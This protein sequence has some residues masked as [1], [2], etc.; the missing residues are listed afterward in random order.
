M[1]APRRRL[2]PTILEVADLA[3]VSKSSVSNYFHHPGKLSEATRRRIADAMDAVGFSL[4]DAART[5]RTGRS[6]VVGYVA[7]ELAA[8]R[9]PVIANA[10]AA[11]LAEHDIDLLIATNQGDGSRERRYLSLFERQR[12]SGLIVSPLGDLEDDLRRLRDMGIP[13]VLMTRHPRALDQPAVSID[14][15]K[16]GRLALEHLLELG[17][18]RVGFITDTLA[19]EQITL[20]FEGARAVA[21]A[22]GASIEVVAT[23]ERSVM[24]GIATGRAI[25]DLPAHERPD[26]LFCVNDLVAIGVVHGLAGTVRVPQDVAVVGYDDIEFAQTPAVPLTSVGTPQ[27]ELGEAAADLILAET[28][29][30]SSSM[31]RQR[32][33]APWLV[34]RASTVAP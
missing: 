21:S 22:A 23:A 29:I 32:E 27:S 4:N 17:R 28:G 8:A 24:S 30:T 12:V 16:G 3:G 15:A 25:A 20:R 1:T 26:A 18:R 10:V 2:R 13:S 9:T 33:F 6:P 7:F 19:V 34:V 5:L 14:H 11:R 31:P